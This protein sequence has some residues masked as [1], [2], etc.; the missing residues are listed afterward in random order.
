MSLDIIRSKNKWFT[1]FILVAIVVVFI[2]GFGFTFVNFGS[3]AKVPQGTAAEVNGDPIPLIEYYKVRDR[4][5]DQFQRQGEVPD[6]LSNLISM[7]ALN[8]LIDLKLLYQNAKELGINVTDE[9][10][11]D[12][13]TTNPA[14]QIDGEFI[15]YDA[16]RNFVQ[17]GLKEQVGEFEQ[18]YKEELLA[19]KLINFINQTVKITDEELKNLYRIQNERVKI[20]YVKITPDNYKDQVK[21]SDEQLK[22]YY[23]ANKSNYNSPQLRKIKYVKLTQEDFEKGVKITEDEV[24]AFYNTFK[25]EYTEEDGKIKD[26]D[27]IKDDI[28]SQLVSSRADSLETEF[29]ENLDKNLQSSSIDEIASKLGDIKTVELT[30]DPKSI[31]DNKDMPAPVVLKI[32]SAKKGDKFHVEVLSNIWLVQLDDITESKM[33]SFEEAKNLVSDDLVKIKAKELA[34][35]QASKIYDQLKNSDIEFTDLDK[36]YSLKPKESNYFTRLENSG[37]LKST[38]LKLDAFRLPKNGSLCSR[39]YGVGDDYYIYTLVDKKEPDMKQYEDRKQEIKE[40]VLSNRIN[41]VYNDWVNS[42]RKKAEI[43]PNVNLFPNQG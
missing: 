41:G 34:K 9:E 36:K 22:Q 18:K 16:Y 24:K 13:I 40:A 29:L 17:Q 42:F 25:N 15:G 38:D 35:T 10:L 4:L 26:Y 7:R 21:L 28:R 11:R 43:I 39:V 6:S 5:I 19:Q 33:L 12:A 30:I 1:R 8:Q 23:E 31:S 3:V 37:E 20:S 2:F 32:D 14:F 27:E